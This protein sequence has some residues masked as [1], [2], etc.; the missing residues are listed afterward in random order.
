MTAVRQTIRNTRWAAALFLLLAVEAQSANVRLEVSATSSVAIADTALGGFNFGNWMQ[1]SEFTDQLIN[2]GP[3]V[4]RFPGGN[5]GDEND[6]T[7]DALTAMKS[8]AGLLGKPQFI[9]QTRVF[10]SRPGAKNRPE[11][12]AEAV[13]AAKELGLE[14]LYWEIGNEPDLYSVNRGD[15]SWTPEKYCRT[16]RAQRQAIMEVDP[17][18][19]F[20]G[21][22]VSGEPVRRDRFLSAFVGACGDV[23]DLLT[24]HI[25][26]TDGK[27]TDALALQTVAEANGSLERYR[28]L[29]NSPTQNP[30]GHARRIEF[31]VTEYGLSWYSAR[32]RHLNDQ[33]AALWAAETTLRLAEGGA[34]VISYFAL[35]GTGGHGVLDISGVPRPSYYAFSLL[36]G[37]NGSAL[38]ARC[39]DS[40]VWAHAAT[41]GQR[42]SLILINS[43]TTEKPVALDIPGWKPV[44]AQAF[45]AQSADK[46][47]DFMR[48]PVTPNLR[49]P[50]RSMA[51]VNYVR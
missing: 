25:Y 5:N 34:A 4:L 45:T 8:S 51:R 31:G 22:A 49:L 38:V 10:A 19:R 29:W 15:P 11:D 20:A 7:V 50:G 43:S 3:A 40:E 46:E 26:P 35:Q 28:A 47:E 17:H 27:Q 9:L 42:L 24:W 33:V 23:V 13:R 2:V 44:D 16:F 41:S 12:A 37:F 21:P 6:L 30:L 39:S 14:V 32:M 1:V 48:L 18:A 36:K